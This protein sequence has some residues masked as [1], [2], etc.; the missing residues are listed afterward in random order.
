MTNLSAS[1]YRE[2]MSPLQTLLDRHYATALWLVFSYADASVTFGPFADTN[3]DRGE[4][5]AK[6][7]ASRVGGGRYFAALPNLL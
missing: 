7:F 3:G 5:E 1:D 2:S 6:A 4:A